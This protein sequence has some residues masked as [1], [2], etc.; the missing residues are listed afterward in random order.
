MHHLLN[1][2]SLFPSFPPSLL[3]CPP[4]QQELATMLSILTVLALLFLCVAQ[5]IAVPP[6]WDGISVTTITTIKPMPSAKPEPKPSSSAK[7]KPKPK[8]HMTPPAWDGFSPR[9]KPSSA[10][11]DTGHHARLPGTP[12]GECDLN[13]HFIFDRYTLRGTRWNITQAELRKAVGSD[14]GAASSWKWDESRDADGVQ[15]FKARV[16]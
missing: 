8:A 1:S 7:P 3:I 6:P 15:T 2:V 4:T 12:T 13:D 16:S 9:P 10:P 5:A 14:G 11:K